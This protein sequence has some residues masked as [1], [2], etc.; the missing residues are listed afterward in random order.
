[1]P[2]TSVAAVEAPQGSWVTPG[3]FATVTS[4]VLWDVG[5]VSQSND[6]NAG[7]SP[8]SAA[9]DVA[10]AVNPASQ[11]IAVHRAAGVTR[12]ASLMS[13]TGSIF[14]GQGAIVDL[15]RMAMP[16][17]QPRAFQSVALGEAGARV[18]GGSRALCTCAVPERL[19]RSG[20][21]R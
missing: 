13:S 18:A 16:V 20:P 11:H 12:A 7:G 6:T 3:P 9:L 4:L 2:Q 14:Q 19:A 1:M 10:P 15:D 17:V 5:A 21:V 8:F